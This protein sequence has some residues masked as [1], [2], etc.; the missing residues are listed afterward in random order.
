MSTIITIYSE[1]TITDLP[2]ELLVLILENLSLYENAI[3]CAKTCIKWR[4][5]VALYILRPK[6]LRLAKVNQMFKTYME[7]AQEG[8][9][10]KLRVFK[11]P[12]LRLWQC[13]L[14]LSLFRKYESHSS[15]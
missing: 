15:K 7:I 2:I 14:I 12:V 8:W 5:T 13:D 9:I 10:L 4:Q 6:L 11:G 1:L 3:S